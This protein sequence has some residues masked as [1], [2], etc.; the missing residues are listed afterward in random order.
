MVAKLDALPRARAEDRRPLRA[1]R[2]RSSCRAGEFE[3]AAEAARALEQ[4]STTS[5]TRQPGDAARGTGE[6]PRA[7]KAA[8][9]VRPRSSHTTGS[10]PDKADHDVTTT[11]PRSPRQGR[12]ERTRPEEGRPGRLTSTNRTR[13]RCAT[14]S[15]T[16]KTG[17]RRRPRSRRPQGPVETRRASR[18]NAP[19]A[20]RPAS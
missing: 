7:H 5:S 11:R 9:A 2:R 12:V 14:R 6:D 1:T 17:T 18:S 3:K 15:K 10:R 16:V 8:I 20:A 13:T 19:T 4:T